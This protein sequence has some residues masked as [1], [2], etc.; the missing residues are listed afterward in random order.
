MSF[1]I[2]FKPQAASFKLNLAA[3]SL[4]LEVLY[5]FKKIISLIIPRL[6]IFL[7]NVSPT[8]PPD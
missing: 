5:G 8:L 4:W 3:C 1:T 7:H 2:G 6:S